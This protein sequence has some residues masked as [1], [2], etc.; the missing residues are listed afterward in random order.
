[1]HPTR[2]C[3]IRAPMSGASCSAPWPRS[4]RGWVHPRLGLTVEALLA[5]LPPQDLRPLPV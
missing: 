1:M 3:R 4:R 5:G 2:S